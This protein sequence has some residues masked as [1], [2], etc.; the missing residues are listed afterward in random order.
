MKKYGF[1]IIII[2]LVMVIVFATTGYKKLSE[3]YVPEE[4]S[5]GSSESVDL[6]PAP[7][8]AV[9]DTDGN[10]VRLSDFKGRPV[11]INFWASW[12]PPCIAELPYFEKMYKKYGEDVKFMMVNLTDGQRETV[13]V[14]NTF[15]EDTAYTFPVYYDSDSYAANAYRTYSIPVTVFIDKEGNLIRRQTGAVSEEML[16]AYILK[17]IG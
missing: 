11:V 7:D 13:D 2:L 9:T 15:I 10:G 8:F 16:E 1:I 6:Q 14:V 5:V 4:A 12:C 3:N 17:I